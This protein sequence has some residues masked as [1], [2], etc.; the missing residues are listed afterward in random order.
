VLDDAGNAVGF[1][2]S[3]DISACD[4]GVA[5]E[6]WA[7]VPGQACSDDPTAQG[8][9]GY[10]LLPFLQGGVIGD[11][12]LENAAVTFVVTGMQSKRG[13]GWGLG[14]YDVVSVTGGALSPLLMPIGPGDHLHVQ[15]T[16][17]APPEATIGCVPLLDP[18]DP[19]LTSIA[20]APVGQVVTL[21]LTPVGVGDQ[22]WVDWGDGTYT[23]YPD[24]TVAID[25]AYVGTGTWTITAY[26]GSSEA[27]VDVTI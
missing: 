5:L 10:I 24:D 16:E 20:A 27:S 19:D 25:H 13:S 14:P 9:Y 4:S 23:F 3:Q 15:Y 11:F 21:T 2:V 8:A 26:R 18:A 17:V 12:T 7:G 6:L 22:I 1:R